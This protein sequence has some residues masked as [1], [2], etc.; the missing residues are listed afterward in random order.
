MF[1]Y[2]FNIFV[3]VLQTFMQI[4]FLCGLIHMVV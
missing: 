4:I 1:E 3:Y 2:V